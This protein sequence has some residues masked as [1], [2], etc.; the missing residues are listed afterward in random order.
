VLHVPI[1]A[2]GHEGLRFG[3]ADAVEIAGDRVFEAA[4]GSRELERVSLVQ[5]VY[6]RE[7]KAGS[8]GRP[9]C[10]RG[11]GRRDTSLNL[12]TKRACESHQCIAE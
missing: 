12:W 8:E 11:R 6:E 4:G 9:H 7:N 3:R 5:V 10:P 1:Y 2:A